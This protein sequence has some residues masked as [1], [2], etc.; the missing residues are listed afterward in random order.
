MVT[1]GGGWTV[2]QRQEDG[3]VDFNR[4][5]EEYKRGVCSLEREHWL[6]NEAVHG[7]TGGGGGGGQHALRMALED[8]HGVQ[9]HTVYRRF[10]LAGEQGNYRLTVREYRVNAGNRLSYNH[11]RKPFSMDDQGNNN[12]AGGNC[13]SYYGACL[14]SAYLEAN[15][16]GRYYTGKY[17]SLTDGIYW[18]AWYVL[19]DRRTQQKYSFKRLEMKTRLLGF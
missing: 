10:R 15:L 5:W 4:T 13:G 16:N 11:V 7:L 9:S 6:V 18:G 8:W 19:T 12:Y 3:S 1:D 14:L 17:S 2:F